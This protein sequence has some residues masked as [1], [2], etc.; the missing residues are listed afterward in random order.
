MINNS[1]YSII[2]IL[3]NFS[4]LMEDMNF[5]NELS[6][7]KINKFCFRK[8][9]KAYQHMQAI[10]ISLWRLALQRSFPSEYDIIF[11]AYLCKKNSQIPINKKGILAPYFQ[12]IL[13]PYIEILHTHGDSDFTEIS[14]HLINTLQLSKVNNDATKLKLALTIRNMYNYIFKKLI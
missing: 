10:T 13:Q 8:R 7:L 6:I 11:G 2:E 12:T 5:S 4:V 1:P 3:T 9:K 14:S